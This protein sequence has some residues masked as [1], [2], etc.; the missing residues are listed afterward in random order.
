MFGCGGD[1]DRSK[2]P[3]MGAVAVRRADLVF[4]TSDNP[5]SE[6]PS[7]IAADILGG[8]SAGESTRGAV[9]VEL[10][11]RLAIRSALTA[12]SRDDVV[13]IAG[14]GHETC[15]SFKGKSVPCD[16]REVARE[17]LT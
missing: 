17:E 16:D 7:D 10:D 1:R 5:R 6:E 3:L 14:K 15:Q 8:M 4:V 9:R 12:A 11:R 2:R 13:L